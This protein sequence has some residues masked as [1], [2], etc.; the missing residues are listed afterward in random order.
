MARP[1][2]LSINTRWEGGGG[3]GKG[4][5]EEAVGGGKGEG[6]REEAKK[7]GCFFIRLRLGVK[8]MTQ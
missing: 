7:L 1:R 2:E 8:F 4:R 5:R 6:R 3:K